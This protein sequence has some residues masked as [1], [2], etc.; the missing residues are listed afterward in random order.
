MGV[1]ETCERRAACELDAD[2][3]ADQYEKRGFSGMQAVSEKTCRGGCRPAGEPAV[4]K[5]RDCQV[6]LRADY[7]GLT[8]NLQADVR[9]RKPAKPHKQGTCGLR[10]GFLQTFATVTAVMKGDRIFFLLKTFSISQCMLENP[11]SL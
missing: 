6:D 1:S 2:T 11:V 9:A 4:M 8:G 7:R 10:M 3:E 5:T